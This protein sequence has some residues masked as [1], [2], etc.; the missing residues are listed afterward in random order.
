LNIRPETIKF[1][2]ENIGG[3]VFDISLSNVFVDRTSKARKTKAKIN[4][5][6]LH[7]SKKLQ[8]SKRNHQENEKATY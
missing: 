3:K 4:K 6:D 5:W 1:L 8:H 2:G 7:Q